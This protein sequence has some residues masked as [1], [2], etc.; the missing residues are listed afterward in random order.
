MSASRLRCAAATILDC[1]PCRSRR[2]ARPRGN[3]RWRRLPARRDIP[4][5]GIARACADVRASR[6]SFS[7][8]TMPRGDF[9][10]SVFS[11]DS[12]SS[13]PSRCR[14]ATMSCIRSWA[15]QRRSRPASPRRGRP[16]RRLQSHRSAALTSAA[17]IPARTLVSASRKAASW[18]DGTTASAKAG[19]DRIRTVHGLAGQSEISAD[20]SRR[21]RQQPGAADIGEEA[22]ADFRHR[23]LRLVRSR[24]DGWNAPTAR[25]RR[26][27]RCR[28]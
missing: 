24:R 28:P 20:L 23:Q 16:S 21:M 25:R 11:V 17:S 15:N 27:S 1:G 19:M 22:E 14:A 13:D 9:S 7:V 26:P 8:T 18:P 4:A 5:P 6:S 10:F 2:R 3:R 12:A